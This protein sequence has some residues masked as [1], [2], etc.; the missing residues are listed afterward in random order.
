MI[1][2]FLSVIA[3]VGA[4]LIFF[5]APPKNSLVLMPNSYPCAVAEISPDVPIDVKEQCRKLKV[6][7]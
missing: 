1:R 6:A 7:Q 3:A 4:V 2:L 5:F